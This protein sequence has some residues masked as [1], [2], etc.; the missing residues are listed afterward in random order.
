MDHHISIYIYIFIYILMRE[1]YFFILGKQII[2]LIEQQ[3]NYS[4]RNKNGKDG[5]FSYLQKRHA[6]CALVA[7]K[8]FPVVRS[9]TSM[10]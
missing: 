5:N 4:G 10:E 9:E 8:T 7:L 6:Y 3:N 1:E 2:T